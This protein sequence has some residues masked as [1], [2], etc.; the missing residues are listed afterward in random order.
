MHLLTC[1]RAEELR[2]QVKGIEQVLHIRENSTAARDKGITDSSTAV[3]TDPNPSSSLEY[4]KPHSHASDLG[5]VGAK[6]IHNN[7]KSHCS[8]DRAAK[9]SNIVASN[10][11]DLPDDVSL[12]LPEPSSLNAYKLAHL[13]V[14]LRQQ[15]LRDIQILFWRHLARDIQIL[16]WLTFTSE[17]HPIIAN[18]HSAIF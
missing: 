7:S 15:L 11:T 12:N 16:F 8:R 17:I 13:L 14:L 10:M 6:K 18:F 5:R 1:I 2:T 3:M 9:P 4:A